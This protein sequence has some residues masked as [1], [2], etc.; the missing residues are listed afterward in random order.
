[1]LFL[2][3]VPARRVSKLCLAA[4]LHSVHLVTTNRALVHGFRAGEAADEVVREAELRVTTREALA[5]ICLMCSRMP[6]G[7]CVRFKDGG[8]GQAMLVCECDMP[9]AHLR[10]PARE[11]LAVIYLMCNHHTYTGAH[12][13]S[14]IAVGLARECGLH[15]CIAWHCL[16]VV[17]CE[18]L[19]PKR[20]TCAR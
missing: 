1:M 3:M 16:H 6:A 19:P 10:V 13:G 18:A 9:D 7:A 2:S 15:T 5:L 14:V 11:V 17:A 8:A 12:C 20:V 4:L